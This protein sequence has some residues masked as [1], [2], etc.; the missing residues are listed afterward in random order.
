M[1]VRR[2]LRFCVR[3]AVVR[4]A[5]LGIAA[6]LAVLALSVWGD[7]FDR[8]AFAATYGG[9]LLVVL[10]LAFVLVALAFLRAYR[11]AP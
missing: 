7:F 3:D 6:V 1:T 10:L 4:P 8:S 2:F 9:A 11:D 5:A